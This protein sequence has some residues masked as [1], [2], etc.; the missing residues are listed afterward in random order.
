MYPSRVTASVL[1]PA[2]R[3]LWTRSALPSWRLAGT[4]SA[5]PSSAFKSTRSRNKRDLPL[6]ALTCR[7]W[8]TTSRVRVQY[9]SVLGTAVLLHLCLRV[10]QNRHPES[11]QDLEDQGLGASLRD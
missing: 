3:R 7:S 1:D 2:R 9:L 11:L 6:V 4:K 5:P 8:A 10:L